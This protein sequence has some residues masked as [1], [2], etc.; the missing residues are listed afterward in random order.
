MR[1]RIRPDV[2]YRIIDANLNRLREGLRVCEEVSRFILAHRGLT[3]QCKQLRHQ[4]TQAAKGLPGIAALLT[5]RQSRRDVGRR[6][7]T[8]TELRRRNT[9]DIFFANSQ[10]AKESL[11]VLEEFSKLR[12]PASALRF[13]AL[14]YRLYALEKKIARHF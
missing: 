10:R 9:S 14:R 6:L 3:A 8:A 11:R 4:V 2:S 7:V 12:S 13:K 5:G 1:N